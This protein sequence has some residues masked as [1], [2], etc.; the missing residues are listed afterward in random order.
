MPT[1]APPLGAEDPHPRT[2]DIDP[3]QVQTHA[4]LA[5]ALKA[6]AGGRSYREL[7]KAARPDA[8][9]T[10]TLSDMF[11][12]GQPSLDTLEVFL[13]ACG[14]PADQRGAW[15]AARERALS[16][17]PPGLQGVVRACQAEPRRLG[18]HAAIDAPG[19]FGD[20]PVYV[21][22]DTDTDPR[23]VRALVR[24]AAE[25]GGF[26]VLVG[27]SSVG[28]TRC[29]F[30]ALRAL[31]P[32]RWLLHPGDAAQIRQ[33]SAQPQ[34]RMVIWLDELQRYLGGPDGL[35]AATVCALLNAGA[36]LIA[37]IW[38][39]R[40]TTYATPPSAGASDPYPVERGVLALADAIHL[41]AEFTRSE[42]QRA[43]AAADAGDA[44]IALA[45]RS[46]D[47]GLTQTIAAAP[48]LVTRWQAADPYAAAVLNAAIDATRLGARSPLSAELL[49]AAVPGYCTPRQ[50]AIAPASWFETALAYATTELHG[51]AAALA[52][53]G[54]P[55]AMGQ[56]SGYL[57]ADYLQQHAGYHRRMTRVP[58]TCWQAMVDHLTDAADQRRTGE[59]AH[60]RL[61]YGYAEAL[62]RKAASDAAGPLA[63]LLAEQG[64]TEEEAAVLR[65][66]A[67]TGVRR[68]ALQLADL[69][70]NQGQVDELEA[71]ADTG[72][73][74][75]AHRLAGVLAEQGRVDELRARAGTGDRYAARL[76]ADLLARQGRVEEL[77]A[78]AETGDNYAARRLAGLL[79][80]QGRVDTL[81]ARAM[82]GD[83]DAAHRLADLLAERGRV[84]E[85]IV[86]WR[87]QAKT[88]GGYASGRLADLLAERGRMGE[89]I[90][91]WRARA[92]TGDRYAARRLAHLL[93]EQGQ[94]GELRTRAQTGDRDAADRLIDLLADQGRVEEL[95]A[96]AETG[97]KYA[98]HQLSN[99]LADQGRVEEL[100]TRAR[101]GDGHAA[102]LL[103]DLLAEEGR[104]E[105]LKA[106]AEIGDKYA[107]HR[108]V[109]L[110]A[111]QG[112]VEELK[113]RAE[114]SDRYA[115][116]RLV[117]LLAE[118][119]RVE[120]LRA[121]AET[122]DDYAARLL[123]H[124]LA[125]QEQVDELRIRAETGDDYA[126]RLLADL[127]AEQGRVE[128]LKA[129][130]ETS[131]RYAA[132][133]LVDLL[134]EQ[135]RVVELR[136]RAETGDDYA[137]RLLA[138]LLVG[139]ERTEELRARVEIGDAYAAKSLINL[140]KRRGRA[141]DKRLRRFGLSPD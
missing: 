64:R 49:R 9:P 66:R 8:L 20:L 71:R 34:P 46:D 68:A 130:A 136:A 75:A 92:E 26:V 101:S 38:P 77:E 72:D 25:R 3:A 123:A 138:D 107:V 65:A 57:V 127:L 73:V 22:R 59:A 5:A 23:G 27:G 106:R 97:D 48:H 129:R 69:L 102:R 45:L 55:S 76:L 30:E 74:H 1:P 103:A 37:T 2:S 120:E 4:E 90:E 119:G 117:D 133:R 108:L 99:L 104:V 50:R 44:R 132:H 96:R 110:L 115:A 85:A 79:I 6:L 47:Y 84:E 43:R 93:A 54:T 53:I 62:Y 70:A 95:K 29:A 41:A 122:G 11:H 32:Q 100:G 12:K 10:S 51:A 116:H 98:A 128:E 86:I 21:E 18:V 28:K 109:D 113:A 141:D 131:D 14:V 40:Y 121:R 78:R 139:Q 81:K 42:R 105:E 88:G 16:S 94:E 83:P 80:E 33:A 35:D 63:E 17:R 137:A 67:E 125:E 118:Q 58:A 19:A 60:Q 112:R 89:A 56:V 140:A 15:R 134:A 114:T 31:V 7:A 39:D 13:R 61:L 24:A 135:G 91:I 36:L 52:A 82:A 87:T 124:L 126:A 111:E